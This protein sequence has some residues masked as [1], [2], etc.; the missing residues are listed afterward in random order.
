MIV[1]DASPLIVLAKLQRLGLLNDLYGEVLMGSVVKAE[2]IDAGRA[3]HALG[4]EQLEVAMEDGWLQTVRLTVEERDLM[5]RLTERSRL[6][7][8]EAEA[9]ALASVRRLRLIV[10]DK[11]ARSVAAASGVE[12]LGT[13]GTLLEAYLRQ[14]LDLG[15]LEVMLR[16]LSQI[17]WLSP[18]VVAEIL[19]LAR[20]AKR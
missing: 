16:N 7:Q 3:V 15:E 11:E 14:Y 20:E 10:D 12:H 19:R 6:D 5:Q 8:G 2:T 4:V 9:I 17:L 13:A 18:A 1:V